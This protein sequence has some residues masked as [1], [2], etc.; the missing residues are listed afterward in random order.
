MTSC[1]RW[2]TA[3]ALAVEPDP[4]LEQYVDDLIEKVAAALPEWKVE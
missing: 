4:E 1:A 3:Y 2:M